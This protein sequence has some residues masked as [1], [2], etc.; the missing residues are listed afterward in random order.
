MI[1]EQRFDHTHKKKNQN[2]IVVIIKNNCLL[3]GEQINKFL[4]TLYTPNNLRDVS[5][6]ILLCLIYDWMCVPHAMWGVLVYFTDIFDFRYHHL[7]RHCLR[8]FSA[9]GINGNLRYL[10]FFHFFYTFDFRIYILFIYY[11][12]H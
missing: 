8:P 9:E 12:Q 3:W 11:C 7:Y 10:L 4:Y 1:V 2:A 5:V 6:R